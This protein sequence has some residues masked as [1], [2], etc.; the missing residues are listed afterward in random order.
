MGV[1]EELRSEQGY[2]EVREHSKPLSSSISPTLDSL[3]HSGESQ[4]G[5]G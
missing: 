2:W 5:E 3:G 4:G 1:G